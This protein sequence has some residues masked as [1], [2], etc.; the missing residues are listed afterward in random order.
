[1]AVLLGTGCP[2]DSAPP[3][4][5]APVDAPV[6]ASL[7]EDVFV[8]AAGRGATE[9][10]AYAAA[11]QALAEAVLGDAAWAAVVPVEVHRRGVDPQRVT[12]TSGGVEM[13][14]G[15]PRERVS[16]MV[17][18]LEGVDPQPRGPVAWQE[19]LQA[20]LRAHA[21]AQ[22]CVRRSA[23]FSA[24]CEPPHT[25]DVDAT[26]A[27]LG[28]GLALVPAYPDGVPVDARG[29]PLRDPTVY[30]LWR[31]VPL[32]G[33]PM[34]LQGP[35]VAA[36]AQPSL[37]TDAQGQARVPLLDPLP[38]GMALGTLEL[39]IDGAALLG[40]RAA[41]AP[42]TSLRIEP[43]PVGLQRWAMV[44]TRGGKVSGAKDQARAV[45]EA[46]LKTAGLDAPQP[47]GS[48][49]VEAIRTATGER[50]AQ[51]VS[52]MADG[53]SGRVDLLLVLT[54]DTRFT[55]RM[56]GG[57]VWYEAEG[58]LEAYDAW[59]G[60]LRAQSKLRVDVDGMGDDKAEAAAARRLAEQL[61]TAVLAS[62]RE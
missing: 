26:I 50:R 56:G 55:S 29:R 60:Q 57:R 21:A 46:Q 11:R 22:A 25:D 27:G 30:V 44:V 43:R 35:G 5:V 41:A 23:L 31:G 13:A 49:D 3:P 9:D 38:D 15:L 10:E 8:Q 20:Y 33:L 17:L 54:Y 62:L 14:V 53:M 61:S 19:S 40:P 47:L 32:A 4:T 6:Q 2:S 51:R 18:E 24:Q 42:R 52:A 59:T 7:G 1:M 36:L 16:A 34:Q 37:I 58:T 48:R 28:D 45:L 39:R 12:R